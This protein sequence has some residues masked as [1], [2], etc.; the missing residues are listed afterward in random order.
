M[1]LRVS[2]ESM[3]GLNTEF[4][5]VDTGRHIPLQQAVQQIQNGNPNYKNYEVVNMKSGTTYVRSKADSST[6]NNIER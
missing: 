2:K 4:V 5:N 1:N 3:T 6:N